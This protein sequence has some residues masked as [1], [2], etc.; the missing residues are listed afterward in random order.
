MKTKGIGGRKTDHMHAV[1]PNNIPKVTN[2]AMVKEFEEVYK[3]KLMPQQ[4]GVRVKIATK[5]LTMGLR[6]TLHANGTFC[7]I[8][9][10][11]NNAYNDMHRYAVRA[12]HLKHDSLWRTQ[13]YWRVNQS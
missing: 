13:P 3:T 11:L 5:L 12:T 1:V 4:V 7:L 9:I 2:K 8:N 6:M 10:D